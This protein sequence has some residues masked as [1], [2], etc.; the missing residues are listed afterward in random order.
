MK[1][2][3]T[4][5]ATGGGSGAVN[6]STRGGDVIGYALAEDGHVVA[7]HYSSGVGYA[8]HD[9]GLNSDWKHEHY[10]KHAPDGYELEWIDEANL[11]AHQGW[12]AAWKLNQALKVEDEPQALEADQ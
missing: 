12:Q 8:K 11:D 9:L 6:G 7:S 1:I 4:A 5:L 2:F 3:L 10:K